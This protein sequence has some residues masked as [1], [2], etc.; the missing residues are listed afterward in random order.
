MKV[1][2]KAKSETQKVLNLV[3]VGADK[4]N[5]KNYDPRVWIREAEKGMIKRAKLG[6]TELNCAGKL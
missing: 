1:I 6:F 5:K 3:D 2:F 4:P